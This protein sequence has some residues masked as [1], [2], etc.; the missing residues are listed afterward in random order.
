MVRVTLN[1][2]AVTRGDPLVRITLVEDQGPQPLPLV[3]EPTNPAPPKGEQQG[4]KR[5]TPPS[6]PSA[7]GASKGQNV[8][9][10]KL[11]WHSKCLQ[12]AGVEVKFVEE[13]SGGSSEEEDLVFWI[14]VTIVD[15]VYEAVLDTG[16]T[17]SILARR[18]LKQAKI[19][20]TTS[21]AISVED[22]RTIRS[23]G[24]GVSM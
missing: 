3:E 9:K 14:T 7:R 8:K 13:G 23:V 20:K 24:R 18:L 2:E 15:R 21:V 1:G 10:R 12:A 19:Q 5:A 6:N 17:L 22:G 4:E 16:T 11:N